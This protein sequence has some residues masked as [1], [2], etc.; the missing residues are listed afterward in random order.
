MEPFD[1]LI[2][3]PVER[4]KGDQ[5]LVDIL[6]DITFIDMEKGPW[7]AGGAA[8]ALA[9]G[10]RDL[11]PVTADIDIFCA[12]EAQCE[13]TRGKLLELRWKGWSIRENE[14]TQGVFNF[15]ANRNN[16]Q[17]SIQ[18]IRFKHRATLGELLTTFDFSV[19]MFA[20]DGRVVVGPE[21]AWRHMEDRVLHRLGEYRKTLWRVPKYC[22]MGFVPSI[23][24]LRDVINEQVQQTNFMPENFAVESNSEY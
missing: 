14:V 2:S 6:R 3:R 11:T 10:K 9:R 8:L 22:E 20:T 12:S 17:F 21:I 7:V 18:I 4:L 16:K 13:E 19:S 24:L 5:P 23:D 1:Q 15:R